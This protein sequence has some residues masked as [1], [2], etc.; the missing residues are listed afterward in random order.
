MKYDPRFES[1]QQFH[2]SFFDMGCGSGHEFSPIHRENQK[3]IE[4]SML[5]RFL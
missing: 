4:L 1:S 5:V 2:K 3:K